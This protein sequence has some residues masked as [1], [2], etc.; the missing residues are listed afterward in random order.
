MNKL[1]YI[2]NLIRHDFLL[3]ELFHLW[4]IPTISV[5]C[6]CK[7]ATGVG[8]RGG[9]ERERKGAVGVWEAG[10]SAHFHICQ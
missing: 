1:V 7:G 5:D 2:V 10:R 3:R 6:K 4:N 9:R 8:S